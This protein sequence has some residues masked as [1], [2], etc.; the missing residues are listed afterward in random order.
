MGSPIPIAI[1]V[2]PVDP[3]GKIDEQLVEYA[4][5]KAPVGD[6]LLL[7][8]NFLAVRSPDAPKM[9]M[10]KGVSVF[11]PS[12]L[13]G[14]FVCRSLYLSGFWSPELFLI[15][16]QQLFDSDRKKTENCKRNQYARG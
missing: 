8:I 4:L 11:M 10:V 7:G 16:R 6:A 2:L 12:P 15:E 9:T 13:L 3:P 5:Q 1:G 14:V